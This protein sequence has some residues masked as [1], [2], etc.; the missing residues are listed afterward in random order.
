MAVFSYTALDQDG[1]YT[2]SKLEAGNTKAALAS[3]ELRKM[4][5]VNLKR[6]GQD[7]WIWLERAIGQVSAQEKIFFTRNIHTMLEAGIGVDQAIKTT[8]EQ[9]TNHQ[10]R[11]ALENINRQL[12]KGQPLHRCLSRWPQ[13][14]SPSYVNLVRVGESSGKLD[15]TL[16]YL[17]VQQER[18]YILRS[19]AKGAMIY[20]SIIVL[21]LIFMVTLMMVFVIPRVT[22]VLA[23]YNVQL[24]LQT[25]ILIGI[26]NLLVHRGLFVLMGAVLIGLGFRRWI[27]SRR[28][29]WQWDE[30]VLRLPRI[31]TIIVEFNLALF[32]RSLS[33][34]L[35]SGVQ[36]DQA[37]ALAAN[38]CTQ[39]QYQRTAAAGQ[40]FIQKGVPL[41]EVL[42]GH[43]RLYPPLMIRMIEVG[44][45]TGKLDQ[46]LQ[47]LAV[48]YEQSVETSMT[49]LSSVIEPALL[50]LIGLTIG[51]V[52]VSVLTPIWQFA[53]TV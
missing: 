15:E 53:A 47:R 21:A 42:K 31:K 9:V 50:L 52:A 46:M 18:D 8:A 3:L 34:L 1:A 49:N 14:F 13:Y 12:Q 38:V 10:F 7:R 33:A 17:L 26:S 25:R 28:G 43:P 20:P 11:A 29:R 5:V 2:K 27:K 22:G 16:G 41:A 32:T 39:S 19:K 35:Q 48:Y 40:T 36:L 30:F 51:Y 4:L 45:K 24:P 6:E 37:M 23:D 44:Q